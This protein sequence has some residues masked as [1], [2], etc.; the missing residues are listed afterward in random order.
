MG[1]TK[2]FKIED[3]SRKKLMDQ[4]SIF[5]D[6]F[7]EMLAEIITNADDS[8]ARIESKSKDLSPKMISIYFDKRKDE[9]VVVDYAEGIGTN[10][11][12]QIFKKYADDTSDTNEK[13]KVR[14][15]FGRGA[16]DVLIESSLAKKD[17]YL[18][19][20][21]DEESTK[22]VFKFDENNDKSFTSE[23]LS[24]EKEQEIRKKYGINGNGTVV[25]FGTGR[26]YPKDV[27]AAI[28]DYYMLRFIF[29]NPARKVV[30]NDLNE[31]KV[32][33]LEH[34]M[35]YFEK[36]EI[37]CNESFEIK[38]KEDKLK[39]NLKLVKN[40]EKTKGHYILV[41]DEKQ[42]VYD[43][44]AFNRDKDAGIDKI[45]GR[46][47]IVGLTH[48]AKKLMNTSGETVVT[49]TRDGFNQNHGFYKELKNKI[50]KYIIKACALVTENE[51]KI[52]SGVKDKKEWKNFFKDVN[53]YF[54][55]ELE[56]VFNGG[57]GEKTFELPAE[58]IKF[59]RPSIP[60]K[61]NNHYLIKLLINPELIEPGSIIQIKY[62]KEYIEVVQDKLLFSKPNEE[63]PFVMVD[64]IGKSVT[65]SQEILTAHC[66]N[67]EAKLYYDVINEDIHLPAYGFDF[68]PNELRKKPEVTREAVMYVDINKFEIGSSIKLENNNK[69]IQLEYMN[70][71]I[72]EE[73]LVNENIAKISLKIKGGILG[74]VYYITASLKNRKLEFPIIVQENEDNSKNNN[75]IINDIKPQS[76]P[77]N[78]VQSYYDND[79]NIIIVSNNITNKHQIP[80]WLEKQQCSTIAEKYAFYSILS[81]E[82][83]RIM[84]REKQQKDKMEMVSNPEAF[85]Q[86]ISEERDKMYKLILKSFGE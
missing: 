59:V 60:V 85:F 82:L 43:D 29:S 46:L 28:E 73:Q 37:L 22:L 79:R 24:H 42:A 49:P 84:I 71:N 74:K 8:Y 54:K 4:R 13:N 41:Y 40:I 44:T 21:R 12:E 83:A 64:I 26:K 11:L 72:S 70:I 16:T 18:I 68:Y 6:N 76:S 17:N 61:L 35:S 19:S 57:S 39:V 86:V 67:Y 45:E 1:E 62:N 53:K 80:N 23:N 38:Y 81:D 78:Y 7:I 69:D 30:F 65:S 3:S 50:D 34:D 66:G 55:E 2:T 32:Y 77:V 56:S 10:E 5:G 47:E 31:D 27:K 15:M 9:F 51:E 58:G 33:Q 48:F 63:L 14:G 36:C 25:C 52:V 75:G 20:F